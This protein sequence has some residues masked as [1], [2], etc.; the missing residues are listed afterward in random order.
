MKR[1]QLIG[2]AWLYLCC[3]PAVTAS[4]SS[5]QMK[6]FSCTDYHCDTGKM[7]S[8]TPGQWQSIR[9]LFSADS[10]PAE[11]RENIRYA[12]ALLENMVGAITG[13]W[14]DL[15]GNFA[16]AGQPGQLDCISESKNTST[17]LQL[18]FDDGLLKWHE[19][20]ERQVRHPFIFNTHWTAVIAD[21]SN[22][23]RF[24]VD[25][26]FR[27]NGQPPHIQPLADWLK[28][29]KMEEQAAK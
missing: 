9:N 29:R 26:W 15:A 11:E 14:R 23:E 20:E 13:T 3:F 27:D 24:A 22:G 12:I 18:M 28:G 17:Y 4:A 6:F 8:L 5:D 16:G 25:S 10:S 19:V 21:R 7:V 1:V 2:I